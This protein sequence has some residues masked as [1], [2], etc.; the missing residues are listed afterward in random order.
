MK[1]QDKIQEK[2]IEKPIEKPKLPVPDW[3]ICAYVAQKFVFENKGNTILVANKQDEKQAKIWL[4][5]F[6]KMMGEKAAPMLVTGREVQQA[7]LTLR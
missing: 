2:P 1:A 4:D 5:M 7:Y 6:I 3:G